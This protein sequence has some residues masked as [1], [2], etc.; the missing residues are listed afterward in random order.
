MISKGMTVIGAIRPRLLLEASSS[1]MVRFFKPFLANQSIAVHACVCADNVGQFLVNGK[2]V[3]KNTG[4]NND[5]MPAN[6]SAGWNMLEIRVANGGTGPNPTGILFGMQDAKTGKVLEV[7]DGSWKWSDRLT[8]NDWDN[9]SNLQT[10]DH[11]IQTRRVQCLR[12]DGSVSA[13]EKCKNSKPPS[14]QACLD[15]TCKHSWVAGGWDKCDA[16]CG[17]GTQTREV[18]CQSSSGRLLPDSGCSGPKPSTSQSCSESKAC[19]YQW[20]IKGNTPTSPPDSS[21][22]TLLQPP[23]G[24]TTFMDSPAKSIRFRPSQNYSVEGGFTYSSNSPDSL[25]ITLYDHTKKETVLLHYVVSITTGMGRKF[26]ITNAV[27][28]S[29]GHEYQLTVS[30]GGVLGAVPSSEKE[31]ETTQQGRVP[32]I[33]LSGKM[34]HGGWSECSVQCGTGHQTRELQ[35][36]R[37]DG[38]VVAASPFCDGEPKMPTSQ[39]CSD[40][41]KCTYAWQYG[42]WGGCTAKCGQGVETRTAQCRRSDGAFVEGSRC[43]NADSQRSCT[44]TN[45]GPPPKNTCTD[46]VVFPPGQRGERAS[47][48]NSSPIVI[49]IPQGRTGYLDKVYMYSFITTPKTWTLTDPHGQRKTVPYERSQGSGTETYNF[50]GNSDTFLEGGKYT[51]DGGHYNV[52]HSTTPGRP[53]VW[54]HVK[55]CPNSFGQETTTTTQCSPSGAVP[56]A[57]TLHDGS[58]FFHKSAPAMFALKDATSCQGGRGGADGSQWVTQYRGSPDATSLAH[59]GAVGAGTQGRLISVDRRVAGVQWYPEVISG[60]SLRVGSIGNATNGRVESVSACDNAPIRVTSAGASKDRQS[61][62]DPTV[63]S[64][65]AHRQWQGDCSLVT[66]VSS[67]ASDGRCAAGLMLIGRGQQHAVPRAAWI[68]MD[69]ST[70]RLVQGGLGFGPATHTPLSAGGTTRWLRITSRSVNNTYSVSMDVSDNG[71]MWT[72]AGHA[73]L[74]LE[75]SSEWGLWVSSAS[76]TAATFSNTSIIRRDLFRQ[77]VEDLDFA[78]EWVSKEKTTPSKLTVLDLTLSGDETFSQ[79]SVQRGGIPPPI[80]LSMGSQIAEIVVFPSNVSEGIVDVAKKYLQDKW[81]VQ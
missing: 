50:T 21:S 72:A 48:E 71:K 44:G 76:Q 62:V 36:R 68:G 23:R 37:S 32:R 78:E 9:V 63:S 19:S 58:C 77:S 67:T 73:P 17:A 41:D 29:A 70:S 34:L 25:R 35:C 79:E 5:L 6:L 16:D 51:L 64:V 3:N 22:T 65:F 8:K 39:P 24:S 69:F 74:E 52:L 7:S 54:A 15:N 81:K 45:C 53:F 20:A 33:W 59:C 57:G 66:K 2:F 43:G 49:T 42:G 46:T 11:G 10:C 18:R 4:W 56:F 27:T 12:S 13:D 47:W 80:E 30:E 38:T 55:L 28:L 60:G 31:F 75:C 26:K 1:A 40:E 14:S 61:H